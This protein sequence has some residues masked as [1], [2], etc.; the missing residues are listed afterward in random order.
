MARTAREVLLGELEIEQ[1]FNKGA[2]KGPHWGLLAA[3][4]VEQIYLSRFL[5]CACTRTWSRM[6]RFR[7]SIY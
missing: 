5:P 4:R 6:F 7:L 2:N 1:R 3:D